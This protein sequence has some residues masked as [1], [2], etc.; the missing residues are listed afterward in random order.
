MKMSTYVDD[1]LARSWKV[2]I[3]A[4]ISSRP[5]PRIPLQAVGARGIN[6]GWAGAGQGAC[7]R[8]LRPRRPGTSSNPPGMSPSTRTPSMSRWPR[9]AQQRR[10]P[11]APT[12]RRPRTSRAHG[13]NPG[14]V[15]MNEKVDFSPGPGCRR[16]PGRRGRRRRSTR[17]GNSAALQH[18]VMQEIHQVEHGDDDDPVWYEDP[19]KQCR[20]SLN[21]K[22][23][24]LEINRV[25]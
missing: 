23:R 21:R 7:L 17:M 25:G 5:I 2:V 18:P 6:P 19:R 15:G 4:E 20:P 24:L 10:E 13:V 12:L 16:W 14:G 3:A 11:P 22:Q 1:P 9:E 8:Q